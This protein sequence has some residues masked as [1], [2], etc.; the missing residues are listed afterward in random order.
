[1]IKED[2]IHKIYPVKR[3]RMRRSSGYY[4]E[5]EHSGMKSIVTEFN[6]RFA[7]A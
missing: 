4:T 2:W 7:I 6:V 3:K 1:M 5:Y